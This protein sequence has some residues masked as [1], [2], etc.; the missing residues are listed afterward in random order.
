MIHI[1]RTERRP[2]WKNYSYHY[3]LIFLTLSIASC[4]KKDVKDDGKVED[5]E[6]V[7][8][9]DKNLSHVEITIPMMFLEISGEEID[10]DKIIAEAKE[11][12]VKEAYK[13]EDGSLTYVIP[14]D[15]HTEMIT[16]MKTEITSFLNEL[17][18]NED[19]M[20][21]REITTNNNYSEIEFLV[22][23]EAFEN[24]F[25]AFAVFGVGL[26]AIVYQIF[27]GVSPDKIK[28]TI[29]LKDVQSG[30]VFDSVTYPDAFDE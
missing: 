11:E 8:E 13:N 26:Q 10:Y 1:K 6:T 3:F 20:S 28:T 18:E 24:S 9:V 25:D 21:I 12:G 5:K 29:S 4:A 17:I 22:D 7:V 30:K 2:R 27:D 16:E 14:K 15:K 23:Q 19:N